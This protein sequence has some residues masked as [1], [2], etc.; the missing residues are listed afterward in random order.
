MGA[1]RVYARLRVIGVPF[2]VAPWSTLGAFSVCS[3]FGREAGI[4]SVSVVP[5]FLLNAKLPIHCSE[6]SLGC[7]QMP[8]CRIETH[9]LRVRGCRCYGR[10]ASCRCNFI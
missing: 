10:Q 3:G 2:V 9:S 4:V 7:H 6:G 5:S 8:S 1:E